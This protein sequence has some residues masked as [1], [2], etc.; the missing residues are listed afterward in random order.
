M[1]KRDMFIWVLSYVLSYVTF[2][3]CGI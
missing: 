2:D 3:G 1:L